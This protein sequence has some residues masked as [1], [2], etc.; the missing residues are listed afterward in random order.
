MMRIFLAG[1]LAATGLT[2]FAATTA[3]DFVISGPFGGQ[4]VVPG[5]AV[6]TPVV[7]TAP[8]PKAA[9]L[10]LAPTEALGG[11]VV[12]SKSVPVYRPDEE[13]ESLPAPKMLTTGQAAPERVPGQGP[14]GPMPS[15]L[16]IVQP[17]PSMAITPIAPRDFVKAFQPIPGKHEVLFRHPGNGKAVAVAFELPP[18]SPRKIVY[19]GHLLVFDYGR[20]EV[21]VHFQLGGKV[22]VTQR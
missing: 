21:T 22:K 18:G 5:P 8:R 12:V 7:A 11:A 14:M 17:S 10:P 4:I 1:V 3:A 13:F 20:H 15:N 6:P 16:G 19:I 2:L 9:G